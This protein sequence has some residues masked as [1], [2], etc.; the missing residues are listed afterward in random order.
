M[1]TCLGIC[2]RIFMYMNIHVYSH[3]H[4]YVHVHVYVYMHTSIYLY[5]ICIYTH[6]GSLGIPVKITLYHFV[7][8]GCRSGRDTTKVQCLRRILLQ[9]EIEKFLH[10][11]V[12][13]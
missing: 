1:C 13:A 8:L 12:E 3:V 7:A 5:I 9:S 10:E 11:S 4:E 2:I 6:L